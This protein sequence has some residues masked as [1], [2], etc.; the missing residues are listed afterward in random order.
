MWI[1]LSDS[2]TEGTW[3]WVDGTPMNISY[4]SSGE[5]NGVPDREEDC[6]EI[7]D[8]NTEKNWNDDSCNRK[9]SWICEKT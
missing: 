8:L 2:E 5:P 9:R 7:L 6:G 1:G 4:W 3:K